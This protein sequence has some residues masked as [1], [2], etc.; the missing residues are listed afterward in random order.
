MPAAPE[1]LLCLVNAPAR[2]DAGGPSDEEIESC[3]RRT[4]EYLRRLGLTLDPQSPG[5]LRHSP[6][7]WAQRFPG[8]GGALYGQATHGWRA[9]FSRPAVITRLPGLFLAGGSTHPGAGV[10]MAVLSGLQ[11]AEQVLAQRAGP[12]STTPL[13]PAVMPGGTSTP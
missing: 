4:F 8:T 11:A 3:E 1:R 7:D 2:G 5:R 10:P 13:R 12:T 6:R 9:S